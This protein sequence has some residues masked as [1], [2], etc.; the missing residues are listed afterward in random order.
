MRRAGL[1]M[2][3]LALALASC[4]SGTQTAGPVSPTTSSVAASPSPTKT[5]PPVP[6]KP[7]GPL[8]GYLL[9][10]DRGN[11]RMLLVD[12]RK[13][14]LWRYPKPNATPQMPFAF[15][16]DTFFTPDLT[17]IISNQ[18]DQETIQVIGFPGRQLLWHYGHVNVSGF[19]PGYL[20]TPDDAYMLPNGTVT[21]A[22]ISNCRVLF[23]AP[24]HTVRK[25][26]GTTNACQ[27]RPP[28]YLDL[29][30][31]DTPM[32]DGGMLITEINGSWIDRIS[33]TGKLVWAVQA[34]IG[35]PSDAQ[36]LGHGKILVADY[37]VPGH[38][39]IMT[40]KGKVL[41][42]YGP[43]SGPGELRFP[44]LAIMLPNGLVAVN[45]DYRHRVVVIDPKTDRIVWQYGH[46]DV[47]GSAS[48][49]LFKP[50]G[51]DFLPYD[52]AIAQPAI[53]R[54]LVGVLGTGG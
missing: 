50:D 19:A 21:V 38:V 44:S 13:R 8:P 5:P 23:I 2:L 14:I 40:T 4:T 24:D 7:T 37:G 32:P 27:H 20:M 12:G 43:T 26:Y 22:D 36:W 10:A 9:I 17:G 15:D 28:Q 30:N 18:E 51:M 45:D 49:Y 6:P 54:F 41:W 16:D 29:P 42:Q 52:A 34:P 31:G 53:R 46:T 48:G 25:Q 47:S 1:A 39:L 3:G 35:Y 11:A 33:P